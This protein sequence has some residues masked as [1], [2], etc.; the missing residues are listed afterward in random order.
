MNN[1]NNQR[2]RVKKYMEHVVDEGLYV[3]LLMKSGI[4]IDPKLK[5]PMVGKITMNEFLKT[6]DILGDPCR[7]PGK[8]RFRKGRSLHDKE[9][10]QK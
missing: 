4:E 5:T 8:K 1:R 9:A 10:T 3:D 7:R 2:K 6:H